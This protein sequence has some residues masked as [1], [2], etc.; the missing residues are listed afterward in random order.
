M[1]A[2]VKLRFIALL[3][4]YGQIASVRAI[5]PP[6]EAAK[7]IDE[8]NKDAAAIRKRADEEILARRAKLI[9]KLQSLQ[10]AYTKEAKLDEAVAIRELIRQLKSN[11]SVSRQ[12]DVFSAGVW[13]PAE[14]LQEKD[15]K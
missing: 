15:G 4:V 6:A 9:D 2:R 14:V 13:E 8:F 3:L 7:S 1:T 12:A 10:D 5:E 11:S